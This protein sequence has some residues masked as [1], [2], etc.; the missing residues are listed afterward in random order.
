MKFLSDVINRIGRLE[1]WQRGFTVS[2]AATFKN[3]PEGASLSVPAVPPPP[4]VPT[5]PP[6]AKML[7]ISGT[8]SGSITGREKYEAYIQVRSTNAATLRTGTNHVGWQGGDYDDGERVVF[9][10]HWNAHLYTPTT[11]LTNP[12]H[13]LPDNVIIAAFP[14]TVMSYEM[15]GSNRVRV[16]WNHV[17]PPSIIPVG[18]VQ[19]GGSAGGTGGDASWTYDVYTMDGKLVD[20]NTGPSGAGFRLTH[21]QMQAASFGW[22]WPDETGLSVALEKPAVREGCS[23]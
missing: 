15:A 12:T 1:K 21:V 13:F 16:F 23:G 4:D 9:H 5:V 8:V 17:P 2:G 7:R 10:N 20:S 19:Q 3:T 14:D 6:G 22:I 11:S 18:L